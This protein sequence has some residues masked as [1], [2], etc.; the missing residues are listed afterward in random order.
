MIDKVSFGQ[1]YNFI[2][3]DAD[4]AKVLQYA[5]PGHCE[6]RDENN[7]FFI[8]EQEWQSYQ[9]IATAIARTCNSCDDYFQVYEDKLRMLKFHAD[10]NK[11]DILA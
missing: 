3:R 9:N 8:P 1:A 4:Q 11:I 10:E 5:L 7:V 6:I 2:C